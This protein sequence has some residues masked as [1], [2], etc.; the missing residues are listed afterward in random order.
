VEEAV[1]LSHRYITDRQLPDKSVSLLDT[2]CARVFLSQ[3]ARPPAIQDCERE[4]Q[5][6]DVELAS[7]ERESALGADHAQRRQ[8][9]TERKEIAEKRLA[10]LQK[11]WDEERKLVEQIQA[12]RA[13]LEAGA[14]GKGEKPN[15]GEVERLRTDL[16]RLEQQLTTVQGETPLVFPVVAGQAIAEVVAGWTGIPVGKMVRDEIKAVMNLHQRLE[17]RVVGQSHALKA[18]AER[19]RVSR[20]NLTDPRRPIG[21]F[22]LLG[23]SGVGKTETALALADILYGGDR[24]M[25]VINM[26]EYKE[27]HKIS[28]LTGSAPG[29]V[30]YGEGGVL[31]EA[32]RRKPYSIV[33]LDEIEKAN[34][35][36]QEIFYQVF[37]KGMLQ[38][39]R[40]NEVNFKNTIIL[41]TTNV[42]TDTIMKMCADPDTAPEPAALR[43]AL[44]ADLLKAFKPAF[45]GRMEVIP[46]YPLADEI[47]QRIIR[48]KLKQI[49]DRVRTNHR[50]AFSYDDAL[51]TTI[52]GRCKEVETGARNVDHIL[53]GTLLPGMATEFLGRMGEGQ[54]ITKAHVTVDSSG[55]F[56]YEI[57]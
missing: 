2:A 52:A 22:M 16:A 6:L 25:V 24:S 27:D 32:V 18:I 37:D 28:R 33:L 1:K 31:T 43:S 10:A 8:E 15:P 3:T 40:G 45:V 36:V 51:V 48:L 47:L 9:L 4:I 13:K 38:D 5:H 54:P 41:I 44:Q 20:A 42:G 26:S 30:G 57:S 55:W 56:V 50:A 23:P 7:L 19:I 12:V 14:A 49:G 21:V 53:T 34:E 39:D 35:S 46:Y 29:Y 11:Q 17:E